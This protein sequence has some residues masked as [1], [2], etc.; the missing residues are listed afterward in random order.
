MPISATNL[1]GSSQLGADIVIITV[2]KGDMAEK[3]IFHKQILC[4]KVE[5]FNKMFNSDFAE[6]NSQTTDLPEDEP[7]P[8]KLLA[9]WVYTDKL[10]VPLVQG[11]TSLVEVVK[12]FGLAEKYDIT[13]LAD[14]T[15]DVLTKTWKVQG[16]LPSASTISLAYE[17]THS[18]S[19]LRLLMART[20]VYIILHQDPGCTQGAWSN[21]AMNELA[22]KHEDLSLDVFA[23]MRCQAG[24]LRVDP[25]LEDPC[26]YHQHAKNA[27]CPYDV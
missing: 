7:L 9:G 11:K 20:F 27:K 21:E 26:D 18:R 12:V 14:Q 25:R 19:K 13:A 4:Q 6:G 5:F 2:G 17:I 1:T 24:K 15:M 8:F 10:E 3:I 23:L 22:R 16:M